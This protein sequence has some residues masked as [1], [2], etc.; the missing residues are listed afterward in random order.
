MVF[1]IDYY[2]LENVLVRC[3]K[4]AEERSSRFTRLSMHPLMHIHSNKQFIV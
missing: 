2:A 1:K 4:K 3:N